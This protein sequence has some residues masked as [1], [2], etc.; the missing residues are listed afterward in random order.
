[1]KTKLLSL[2]I[3]SMFCSLNSE[4]FELVS[5][6]SQAIV[7]KRSVE[8]NEEGITVSYIFSGAVRIPDEIY[9][10]TSFIEIPG[11]GQNST[12]GEPSIPVRTDSFEIPDGYEANV[13]I[14]SCNWTDLNISLSPAHPLLFDDENQYYSLE[15]VPPI[16]KLA[17]SFPDNP[18]EIA[19]LQTYRDRN[20]IYVNIMPVKYVNS[21]LAKVCE[22]ITFRISFTPAKNV[23]LKTNKKIK[24]DIDEDLRENL[25][26]FSIPEYEEDAVKSSNRTPW[27]MAP[28]Y[29]ILSIPKYKAQVDKFI[30][31]KKCMGFNAVALY[32]KSWST[33]DIK[34]AIKTI[35]EE[36]PSLQYVLLIGDALS[37]PPVKHIKGSGSPL[38]HYSDYTYGCMDGED[39]ME[40]DVIVGRLN[41]SNVSEASTV[42]NKIINYEKNPQI[43]NNI[44]KTAVHASFFQDKDTNNF[45]DRRFTKTCEDIRNGLNNESININRVYY[46]YS[47][48]NPTNWNKGS[49]SYGEALPDELLKPLFKWDGSTS[50]IIDYINKGAL[51]VL[52]RGHG[53]YNG[54]A[55]PSLTINSLS[56]L[57][58]ENLL[59][60]FFNIHC[61]SGAFG[62]TSVAVSSTSNDSIPIDLSFAE[63]LLRYEKGGAVATIAAS[64]ISYSG[65]NDAFVMEMFQ[66]I[67][68]K[69]TIV[70]DFPRYSSGEIDYEAKPVYALGKIMRSGISGMSKRFSGSYI[71]Y[72][73]RIF[74]CFGDPTMQLYTDRPSK[75]SHS[76]LPSTS[77]YG[78]STNK[79]A[80]VSL[81]LEDGSVMVSSGTY[82][83]YTAYKENIKSIIISGH[84]SI[85][86]VLSMNKTSL[87]AINES[88]IENVEISSFGINLKYNVESES[89]VNIRLRS[90]NT[91]LNVIKDVT[92]NDGEEFISTST[93]EKGCYVIELIEDGNIVD[94]RKI[95]IQ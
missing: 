62:H 80:N 55:Q 71:P 44:Y 78:F 42:I 76:V 57:N 16:K 27:K 88:R 60:V 26:T 49:F 65:V 58:N 83:D 77:L 87:S 21:L 5:M 82:F 18:I 93:L 40:Q 79:T 13:S 81:I 7:P 17:N 14:V 68:P 25:F 95:L 59:P 45:E 84:N 38:K 51:Y 47:N 67:W 3:A 64:E 6:P 15:N 94:Y 85:P 66:S 28:Y 4:A 10:E 75:I 30:A 72:T 32:S 43:L 74:H 86:Q 23:S 73:K 37:L 70:T 24:H 63:A 11:F 31:W 41:V 39:D 36:E 8:S 34:Y 29:L 9:K 22:N 56:K 91:S 46:A 50:D 90:I 54:W 35:Y 53:S 2:I 61:Q 19:N 69:S 12:P 33:S 52:H 92:S 48:V 20:I 89:S 1:M